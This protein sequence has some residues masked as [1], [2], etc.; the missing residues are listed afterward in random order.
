MMERV[1]KYVSMI[2]VALSLCNG[3][4]AFGQGE[5]LEPSLSPGTG[6][7]SKQGAADIRA[8]VLPPPD[9]GLVSKENVPEIGGYQIGV[10]DILDI[11]VIKPIPFTSR[12][13]V[14]SDGSITFPYIGS[15]RAQGR[16]LSQ[17]QSE[18]QHRLYDGGYMD[19]P[20]V[21]VSLWEARSK[22][23]TIYGQV[24][25]PGAYL[26]SG[27][28]SLLR[29]ISLAGGLSVPGSTAMIKVLHPNKDGRGNSE[30]FESDITALI[31]GIKKDYF[32]RA[33]DTV[34][35]TLDKFFVYGEVNHPGSYPVEENMSFLDAITIAGS[36]IE[37]GSTGVIKLLRPNGM[38]KEMTL[39]I[40]DILNGE[41]QGLKVQSGDIIDV[42][43]DKFFIYGQ[44]ARPGAYPVRD[45][46]DIMYAITAA[47]G[48]IQS[49][50]RGKIK[51]FRAKQ[52]E[53]ETPVFESDIQ[54]ILVARNQKVIVRAGDTIVVTLDRFFVTGQVNH[55]GT[56][57]VEEHM[58]LLNAI[59]MAGGLTADNSNGKIE[60]LR[61]TQGGGPGQQINTDFI[62]VLNGAAP[63]V[64]IH[65]L[66]TVVVIANK[67]Y[68]Y[69]EVNK[70]G[71]YSLAS[72]TTALTAI[73]IAGGFTR[74][75]SASRVKVVRMD[76]KTGK[77]ELI[78]VNIAQAIAGNFKADVLLM[79]G[80]VVVVSEGVF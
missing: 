78:K 20:V 72:K 11:N 29:A 5:K 14:T 21:S 18:I 12:M 13:T 46:M 7:V 48:F 44:I 26:L 64:S 41:D 76:E 65:A 54:S 77:Y 27:G 19:D 62:S 45:N 67:F 15:V 69:G 22:K 9:V 53:N 52:Q 24:Y 16:T 25:H 38:P 49:G 58:S 23:F 8:S 63:S 36:F 59:S 73:S 47:G 74:F 6:L 79:P 3:S 75:G 10:D 70:P 51:L 34:V 28:M 35:V 61:P 40:K 17:V 57:T 43:V 60:L 71:M 55:P 31:N 1:M 50:S 66:D 56:Y 42:M 37:R 33:G 39:D 80:D 32:I 68:V 2:M 30:V 4:S